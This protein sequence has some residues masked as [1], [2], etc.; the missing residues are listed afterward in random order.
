MTD[1]VK[2]LRPELPFLW[3]CPFCELHISALYEKD[4]KEG[5]KQHRQKCE[6]EKKLKEE[7]GK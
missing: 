4:L 3:A 2:T 5:I 1:K 6:A 7:V